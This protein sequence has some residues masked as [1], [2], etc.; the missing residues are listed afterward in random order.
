MRSYYD[1]FKEALGTEIVTEDEYTGAAILAK[2][3]GVDGAAS[4]LDADLLDGNHAAA[5]QPAGSYVTTSDYTANDVLT[6][7]KTVD[8]ADSGLDADLLDGNHAAAFALSNDARLSDARTPTAHNH[9]GVYQT[10]LPAGTII[11]VPIAPANSIRF[12]DTDYLRASYYTIQAN[13]EDKIT[14]TQRTLPVSAIWQSITCNGSVFCT[15][16]YG[17]SIAATSPDGITWTQRTLP[18]STSW[19]SITCNGSIFCAVAYDSSI[20][21]TGLVDNSYF[22]LPMRISQG[23]YKNGLYVLY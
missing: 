13:Y 3:L 15:V 14:W 18:V 4:G 23:S 7:I 20:A 22:Y 12:N 10:I 2:L 16:A 19:R 11:D 9:T 6:K 21:A 8:G 17:S 1:A 5:F